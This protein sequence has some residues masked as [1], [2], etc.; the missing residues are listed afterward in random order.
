MSPKH[1]ETSPR[2]PHRVLQ[3]LPHLIHGGTEFYVLRMA[4]SLDRRLFDFCIC[5][6]GSRDDIVELYTEAG[7]AP[8]PIGHRG[9]LTAIRT[10]TRLVRLIKQHG[11][12]VIQTHSRI[13]RLYGQMAALLTGVPVIDTLHSHYSAGRYHE[14]PGEGRQGGPLRRIRLGLERLLSRITVFELIAVSNSV[15][16]TWHQHGA[17]RDALVRSITVVPPV[18]DFASYLEAIDQGKVGRIRRDLRLEEASPVLVTVGRL[19]SGKNH[20]ALIPLTARLKSDWPRIV[21]LIVGDGPRRDDLLRDIENAGLVDNV[22][23]LGSRDD[24]AEVLAVADAFLLPSESEGLSLVAIE[25]VAAG[26]P[27]ISFDLRPLETVLLDGE[28]A[29]KAPTGDER[30]F[31]ERTVLLLERLHEM[32]QGALRVRRQ[33]MANFDGTLTAER[34]DTIYS[35]IRGYS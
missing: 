22:K 4:A 18:I 8:I 25:A 31:A 20:E 14:K 33:V 11:S 30:G 28:N 17:S 3:V 24:I 7:L 13:D 1:E 32:K 12:D 23:L 9:P 21:L 5:Y 29:L 27:V 19:V 15:I 6:L 35:R 10:V 2:H 34:L 26:L 16:E